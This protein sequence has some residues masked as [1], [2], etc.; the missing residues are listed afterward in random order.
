MIGLLLFF[1]LPTVR[2]FFISMSDWNLMRPGKFVGVDNYIK[3]W[4]DRNFWEVDPD[5][6][7]LRTV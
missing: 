4:G 5:H 2:A 6:V 7:C 3:L 1:A